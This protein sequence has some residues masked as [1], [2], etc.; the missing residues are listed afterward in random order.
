MFIWKI[1]S[2]I[3][4]GKTAHVLFSVQKEMQRGVLTAL[5]AGGSPV[6]NNHFQVPFF[7]PLEEEVC[8]YKRRNKCWCLLLDH[9]IDLYQSGS[10]TC[11]YA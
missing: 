4:K 11:S 8:K 2:D 1:Y 7:F 6:G 3:L 5:P 9:H 10:Q